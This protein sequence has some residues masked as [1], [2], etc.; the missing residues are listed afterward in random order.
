MRRQRPRLVVL[1]CF[2]RLLNGNHHA[3][4]F[5]HRASL[6]ADRKSEGRHRRP[7]DD[8]HNLDPRGNFERNL[9]VNGAIHDPCDATLQNVAGANSHSN[10]SSK[11]ACSVQSLPRGVGSESD[12]SETICELAERPT[13]SVCR[14][15]QSRNAI[16]GGSAS[17]H[18]IDGGRHK[19]IWCLDSLSD[20]HLAL[21]SEGCILYSEVYQGGVG[22]TEFLLQLREAR[23]GP[24][25]AKLP[26]CHGA[27][28]VNR[29][30]GIL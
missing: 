20:S 8:R 24:S 5:N 23:N 6:A 4:G 26:R 18:G 10:L 22:P 11:K 9:A 1:R 13:P 15:D 27:L 17:L 28:M 12:G 25:T 2:V 14:D 21:G 30:K 7:G 3:G 29:I 16:A 19:P